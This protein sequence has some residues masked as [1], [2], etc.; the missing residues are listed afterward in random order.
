MQPFRVR[1]SNFKSRVPG[2]RLVEQDTACNFD[3]I[4][5]AESCWRLQT[6]NSKLESNYSSS[7]LSFSKT[8][9]SSRVVTSPATVPLVAI[10]RNNLL[11]IFPDLVLGRA[12]LN[13]TSSGRAKAR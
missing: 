11:I 12:S 7:A 3:S 8:E 1:V 10:S 5:D 6:R 4:A 2:F 13:R 9:K